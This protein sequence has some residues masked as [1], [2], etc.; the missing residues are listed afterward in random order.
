LTPASL[1]SGLFQAITLL[2]APIFWA[3]AA[4]PAA[5][6]HTDPKNELSGPNAPKPQ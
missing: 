2:L 4:F 6:A 1:T 5:P 3:A